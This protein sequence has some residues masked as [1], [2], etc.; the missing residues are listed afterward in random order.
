MG[1]AGGVL[2]GD[3]LMEHFRRGLF[4]NPEITKIQVTPPAAFCSAKTLSLR[5]RDFCRDLRVQQGAEPSRRAEQPLG[6]SLLHQRIA[7]GGL[8][9]NQGVVGSNPAG[10]AKHQA[11]TTPRLGALCYSI[12]VVLFSEAPCEPAG[13]GTCITRRSTP[14]RLHIMD[15]DFEP[16]T[17]LNQPAGGLPVLIAA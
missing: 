17:E 2:K 15:D 10:R 14:P 16:R 13:G 6:E 5:C 4:E 12:R 7:L 8:P 9:T 1:L 11:L 3:R